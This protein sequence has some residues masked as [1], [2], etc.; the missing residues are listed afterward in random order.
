MPIEVEARDLLDSRLAELLAGDAC[1]VCGYRNRSAERYIAAIL[2]E[3]VNDRGFRRDL[4][5]AR[6]FCPEH[7]HAAIAATRRESGGTVA[8]A[9]LF[10]AIAAVRI[11]ELAS[12]F[13]DRGRSR[14]RRLDDTRRAASC[15]VCAESATA[16][17][18]AVARLAERLR[19]QDWADAV[20]AAPLCLDHLATLAR[21]VDED[22]W[23][24]VGERQLARVDDLI[25]NLRSFAHHSSHDRRHL[26]TDEERRSADEA[27]SLLGGTP[28][29]E[30]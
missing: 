1:P 10:G 25:A 6:G 5:A 18:H 13:G 23:R 24:P 14:E 4:D 11:R 3:M 20:A 21:A 29:D 28:P 16:E 9:I 15:P 30:R 22:T 19:R 7:T 2:G 27:A 8:A 17:Q 12:A 26:I